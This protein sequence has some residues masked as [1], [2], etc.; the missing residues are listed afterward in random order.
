GT[1]LPEDYQKIDIPV[2]VGVGWWD[3][4]STMLA[5]EALQQAQSAQDC[6]LLIGA[7]DHAGNIGPRPVLG[8]I[9]VSASVMDTVAYIEQ[10]LALHLKGERNALATAPRCRVFLTG[11]N[12]WDERAGWPHPHAVE[13]PWHLT[14]AG[15]ARSLRGNGCL[16]RGVDSVGGSD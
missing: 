3:D 2:L 16:V 13:T 7:W 14:S 1:L 5:W 10:F 4:Q 12:R 11:E 9:D 8:G 15:D 6:R